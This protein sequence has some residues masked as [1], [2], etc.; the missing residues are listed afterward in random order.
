MPT[1]EVHNHIISVGVLSN[2]HVPWHRNLL[3]P[4]LL[5]LQVNTLH[6]DPVV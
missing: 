5:R 3:A 2:I 4:H 1:F 6:G